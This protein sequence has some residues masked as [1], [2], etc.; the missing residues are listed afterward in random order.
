MTGVDFG[1]GPCL[2][3]AGFTV[4]GA[5]YASC[6]TSFPVAM[7]KAETISRCSTR[8]N[9]YTVPPETTG[10]EWPAPTVTF[11]AGV[12]FSGHGRGAVNPGTTPSRFGP[13]HWFQ[14]CADAGDR[15]ARIATAATIGIVQRRRRA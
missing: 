7:S 4:Y 15:S 6:H 11:H 9:T 13:R 12:R 2:V 14:S 1:P 10:D 5:S 3:A 8:E